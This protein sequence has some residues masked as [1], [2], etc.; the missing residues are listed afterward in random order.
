EGGIIAGNKFYPAGSNQE[1]P[2]PAV[3]V[4]PRAPGDIFANFL[5]CVR[6][7]KVQDLHADVLEGHYSSALC[8]LA[9]VS[10]RLGQDVSPEQF[11]NQLRNDHALQETLARM[12]EHLKQNNIVLSDIRYRVG[13]RLKIDPDTET[14]VGDA[15]ANQLLFRQYRPPFVVPDRVR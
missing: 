2:L 8:H 9:N 14:I 3:D 11:R 7:R 1:V 10:Y 12:E 5:A 13:R 4:P 6:S 15:E